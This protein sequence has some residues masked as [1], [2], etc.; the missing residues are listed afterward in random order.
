MNKLFAWL[1]GRS[2]TEKSGG[3]SAPFSINNAE[4]SYLD[5]RRASWPTPDGAAYRVEVRRPRGTVETRTYRLDAGPEW[6]WQVQL[7]APDASRGQLQQSR[8]RYWPWGQEHT[9]TEIS[10][11]AGL[12]LIEHWEYFGNGELLR[13]RSSQQGQPTQRYVHTPAEVYT[14][15]EQMPVYPGGQ[16]QLLKDISRWTKYP[17]VSLRNRHQGKVFVKFVVGADGLVDDIR[18]ETGVTPELDAA[19][20]A[21]IRSMRSVRFRPGFQNWRAVSVHF[22]VPIT[23]AIN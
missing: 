16:E 2:A 10:F 17:A 21:A 15:T 1:R 20:L 9:R 19:A 6:L 12:R 4:V 23:F 18:I 22:T 3:A 14:Y 8:V 11:L 7:E 13:H 5:A